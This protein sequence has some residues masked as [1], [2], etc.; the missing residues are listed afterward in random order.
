M[1]KLESKSIVASPDKEQEAIEKHQMFGWSLLSSQ[2]VLSKDS[3]LENR[4]DD[5]WSVTTTTNYVKLVFQ[6][7]TGI[8]N[9]A[10][11]KEV[12]KEYWDA[13]AKANCPPSAPTLKFTILCPV[14]CAIPGILTSNVVLMF[15]GLALGIALVICNKKFLYNPRLKT[16]SEW[17]EK[18]EMLEKKIAEINSAI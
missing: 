9:L 3:H 15:A 5:L 13:Y 8:E 2:E 7:D 11:I 10:A 12:E 14:I 6:R 1:A 16:W 4:G 17:V 18:K